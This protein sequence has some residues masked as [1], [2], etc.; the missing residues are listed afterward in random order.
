MVHQVVL[1]IL[2]R[3]RKSTSKLKTKWN[4]ETNYNRTSRDIISSDFKIQQFD[5]V[6]QMDIS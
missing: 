4:R 5:H 2:I 1:E 3:I 6:S